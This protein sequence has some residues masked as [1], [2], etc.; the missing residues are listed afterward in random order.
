MVEV[1]VEVRDSKNRAVAGL[2]REDFELFDAGKRRIISS[3]RIEDFSRA[4]QEQ[5][6]PWTYLHR[7]PRANR[8]C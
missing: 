3:F 7:A 1:P 5:S 8:R 4:A 6:K 2:K